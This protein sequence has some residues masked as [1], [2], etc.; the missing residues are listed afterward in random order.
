MAARVHR[1]EGA[2]LLPDGLQG[3]MRQVDA[4]QCLEIQQV[5]PSFRCDPEPVEAVFADV[6]DEVAPQGNG[7]CG[8]ER[9]QFVAVEAA[10]PASGGGEPQETGAVPAY[11][12]HEVAGKAAFHGERTH[13]IPVVDRT[14]R[15][16]GK[17]A[18]PEKGQ[19]DTGRFY[20]TK[21]HLSTIC[22]SNILIFA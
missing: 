12:I 19:D 18:R 3:G 6:P 1:Q 13:E 20:T 17:E 14:L 10:Q 5:Q 16:D 8:T 15:P 9:K 4:V 22:A 7:G 21:E 2:E 11:V